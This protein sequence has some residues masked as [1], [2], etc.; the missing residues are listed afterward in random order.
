MDF[1]ALATNAP[2]PYEPVCAWCS[3]IRL[4]P[5]LHMHMKSSTFQL[6][7]SQAHNLHEA[8]E[9]SSYRVR[10]RHFLVIQKLSY[11]CHSNLEYYHLAQKNQWKLLQCT[12]W[13]WGHDEIMTFRFIERR[14]C[15][16]HLRISEEPQTSWKAV[17]RC[18]QLTKLCSHRH[19]YK[20]VLSHLMIVYEVK[21][22]MYPTM[23]FLVCYCWRGWDH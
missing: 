2:R 1:T 14:S 8:G 19:R 6:I 5:A 11:L 15:K 3:Y 21:H 20:H 17:S 22:Q 10:L 12:V 4:G 23:L 7:W 16:L 9:R 13:E 18:Q